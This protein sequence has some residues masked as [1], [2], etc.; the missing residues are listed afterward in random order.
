MRRHGHVSGAE[1][2]KLYAAG[3]SKAQA[4]EV[5]LGVAVSIL[6]NFAHHIT[7]C[8]LDGAFSAHTW[9]ATDVPAPSALTA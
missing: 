2:Q 6:P 1:L 5:V 8:P 7:Q 3:Y 9:P 4:L